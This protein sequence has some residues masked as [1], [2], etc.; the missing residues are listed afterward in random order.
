MIA[1]RHVL[2]TALAALGVRPG[3]LRAE[4]ARSLLVEARTLAAAPFV[5]RSRP[6]APPFADLTYDSFRGIRPIPGVTAMR[7]LGADWAYDLMPPGLYFP[8]PLD[9]EVAGADG[10]EPVRFAPDLF[11]FE[12]RYFDTIPET[13]PGAGFTGLR[14]RH[15]I[16][17]PG[18]MDEVMIVQGATYFRAVARDLA[19]GLSARAVALGTGGSAPEEFPRF[20]RLR[21][22]PPEAGAVRIE[23]VMDSPS[24]AGYM[25]MS[26]H[27]GTETR[28]ATAVTLIPRRRIDDIGIAPLTSMYL[29][30]PLRA[31]DSDDFRPRVHDSN[32]L[33]ME[34]GA[35]EVLW[36]PISNPV[37]V[38]TSAFADSGVRA[39]GLYQTRRDFV[40]FEDSEA[41]YHRRPSARVV[42]RG[43]WGPG[44][45]ML[46]EI[47]TGEEIFDNIVAF[48]RPAA[49]LLAGRDYRYEYDL[50]FTAAPPDLK[51]LGP[52]LQS[53]S[54]R[55]HDMPGHRR[56]VID[57]AVGPGSDAAALRADVTANT[58]AAVLSGLTVF[59]LNEDVVRTSFL[60]APGA[61]DTLELRFVL[62][63][64]SGA[65][66][67]PVWLHRWTRA[68]DGHV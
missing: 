12:P 7:P 40:D 58:D 11:T 10:A 64:A 47:P 68:R 21:L 23:A 25:E 8:D 13:S 61:A 32:V 39:F 3:R 18:V 49:P 43:N 38:E 55:Q 20:T 1:R 63:D 6:L 5:D 34:N 57:A 66:V 29:K 44:A 67:T 36:R 50:S 33:A 28:L 27:P 16:N 37:R 35:G 4:P 9:I 22:W 17:T 56:Y 60:L 31:S 65:P 54:G 53:R 46:V 26:V 52:F 45:V 59:R 14:L 2:L 19:Y 62:R 41:L 51:E 48:W 30:G 24:L 15:P 42:P